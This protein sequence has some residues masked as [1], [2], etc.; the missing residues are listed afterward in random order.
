M[1][2]GNA[3]IRIRSGIYAARRNIYSAKQPLKSAHSANR[4]MILLLTLTISLAL[5]IQQ[6]YQEV[7]HFLNRP[8]SKV[9][10]ENQWQ[11]INDAEIRQ[12]LIPFMG[13]GFFNFD[14][15]G[16]KKNLEQHPWIFRASVKRIWPDTLSLLLTEQ[17][18]I[19]RWGKSQLLNQQGEIFEPSNV[20]NLAALPRL[21]GPEQSQFEV[22]QQYQLLNQVFFP[23]GLRLTGL[24]LS[25][26]G[27]WELTLNE[28]MQVVV[29]RTNVI[30][31][32]ERF[33]DFYNAQPAAQA[34]LFESVDLRYSN[35]LAIKTTQ[36]ELAGVAVR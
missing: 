33:V 11:Q 34:A 20:E 3:T 2:S 21:R 36:Q 31:R 10:I 24:S 5:L 4:A 29:G 17:V 28:D 32:V 19:A 27:S 13:I 9:R 15:D 16:I 14:V 6:N 8:V 12:M 30:A 18:A 35:G 23:V 25:S 1:N 7:S 26:R 22:M